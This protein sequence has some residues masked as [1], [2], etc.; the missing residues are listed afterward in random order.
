MMHEAVFINR[1]DVL[2]NC[3]DTYSKKRSGAG[4]KQDTGVQI[5]SHC[6]NSPQ[7]GITITS[8][9][10]KDTGRLEGREKQCFVCSPGIGGVN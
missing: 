3:C 9:V 4:Q 10:L 1:E 2:T 7:K 5:M 8:N 6:L